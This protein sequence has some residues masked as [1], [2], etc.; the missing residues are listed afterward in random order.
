MRRLSLTVLA[1]AAF[2]ALSI[3]SAMAADSS[4]LSS[5]EGNGV[6]VK[7]LD[8]KA[9]NEVRGTG[10]FAYTSTMP[11][12]LTGV[13]EHFISYF[14]FGNQYDYRSYHYVGGGFNAGTPYYANLNGEIHPLVGDLWLADFSHGPYDWQRATAILMEEMFHAM[15]PV[16]DAYGN[17]LGYTPSGIGWFDSVGWNRPLTTF[18]W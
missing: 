5:L 2:L 9:L 1:L 8:D 7:H 4:I 14:G 17:L 18:T 6:T 3:G 11:S 13:R 15:A 16:Y 12:T 10:Y